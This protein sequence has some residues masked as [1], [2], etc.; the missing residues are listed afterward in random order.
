MIADSY[1]RT[2]FRYYEL[3]VLMGVLQAFAPL[4]IDMYLPSMP[5]LEKVF[6]ATT[7]QVQITLVTFL[8]GYALG[9]SLYGPLTDRFGRKP[10]LYTS[11]ALFVV[12]SAACAVSTSINTLAVFRLLQAIGACG[13]AVV[14]RAMVRDLFPPVELRRIFSMLVLVLGVSPLISPFIG[15]YLLVW[16]GWKSIFLTQAALGAITLLAM[17]FRLDESL[18]PENVRP[19]HWD[20]IS[21]SYTQLLRDRTFLGASLVCGFS[22]AGMFAYIASAP[23]VFINLYKLPPQQFGWLFAAIAA[24]LI[25]AS[26]VNGRMSRG[27]PIW[28]VL[29]VANL[30][31]LLSGVAV[32]VTASTGFGGLVGIFAPVFV[33]MCATGFVFP[34]GNA[35]AMMRHGN[36][37]GTASALLGTNQFVIAAAT[38]IVLG[39]IDN[40]SAM[41]MAIV[42]AGCGA[43]ATL[44]NYLS[45][46]ARLEIAPPAAMAESAG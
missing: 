3:I 46:G 25:G 30:A 1:Q 8:L 36:M 6:G 44:L 12:S 42:I 18:A 16:F 2:R 5:L 38:T 41:P 32:L 14:S 9:Q 40:S 34:N 24:G 31:Q 22:S 26:Q 10:P 35:V 27:I 21:S 45:L 15:G 23:F 33:Y 28:K 39:L 13:G 11:L 29:R 17:H 20:H 7:A 4:S 19:L 43:A 37:A